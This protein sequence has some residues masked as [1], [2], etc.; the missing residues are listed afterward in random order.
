[1]ESLG[2]VEMAV[3]YEESGQTLEMPSM[4]IPQTLRLEQLWSW[5]A[6]AGLLLFGGFGAALSTAF[7]DVPSPP[8]AEQRSLQ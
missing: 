7:S 3:A 1:M 6:I 5:V 8:T 4:A 2:Y